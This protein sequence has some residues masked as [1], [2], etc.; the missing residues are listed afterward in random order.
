M[1]KSQND[2]RLQQSP[3][4]LCEA[5]DRA[6]GRADELARAYAALLNDRK[7]FQTRLQKEQERAILTAQG[8]VAR[9]LID[10]S[11]E[12]ERALSA[13]QGDES[14]LAQGIRLIHTEL[15]RRLQ[16]IGMK[17]M[18]VIG[19]RFDPNIAEA[20]DVLPVDRPEDDEMVVEEL[21]PG[22]MLGDQVVRAARVTVGRY[23]APAQIVSD[24][25]PPKA[26]SSMDESSR[27]EAQPHGA[28]SSKQEHLEGKP[29]T[30]ALD[31]LPS[32]QLTEVSPQVSTETMATPGLADQV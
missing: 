6:E 3:E 24:D 13:A 28:E 25:S 1:G 21:R 19:T 5:I 18:E 26:G 29:L 11:D 2:L 9:D 12:L 16:S 7:S 27:P 32:E 22:F 15:R 4:V 10:L 20:I 31:P 14:P 17:R 8:K 23:V 30:T